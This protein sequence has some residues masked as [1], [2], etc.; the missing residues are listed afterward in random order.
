MVPSFG[1]VDGEKKVLPESL[2]FLFCVQKFY[3]DQIFNNYRFYLRKNTL[4][5]SYIICTMY[6]A[7]SYFMRYLYILREKS[8]SYRKI[9]KI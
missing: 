9:Y 6:Y 8:I 4:Y 2:R 5:V 1:E 3:D 7:R